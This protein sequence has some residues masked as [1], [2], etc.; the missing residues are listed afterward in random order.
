FSDID[1]IAGNSGSPVFSYTDKLVG[2]VSSKYLCVTVVVSTEALKE[3]L[4]E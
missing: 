4:D 1:V 2:I 3:F